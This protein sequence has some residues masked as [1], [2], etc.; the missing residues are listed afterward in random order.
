MGVCHA[1]FTKLETKI[2]RKIRSDSRA[3]LFVAV[4]IDREKE[5]KVWAKG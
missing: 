3:I 5:C 1:A 2:L 4:Q